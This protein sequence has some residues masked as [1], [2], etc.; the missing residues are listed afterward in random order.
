MSN[1]R[2]DTAGQLY[3]PTH[4]GPVTSGAQVNIVG[5]NGL[6]PATIVSGIAVPNKTSS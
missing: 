2:T 6:V 4:N 1:T 3:Q 5:S